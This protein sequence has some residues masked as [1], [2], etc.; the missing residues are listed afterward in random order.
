MDKNVYEAL[1]VLAK[2]LSELTEIMMNQDLNIGE[3]SK[4]YDIK[5]S[6][7]YLINK[8]E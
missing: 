2:A 8:E 5:N 1:S 7:E 6:I 4:L 3:W